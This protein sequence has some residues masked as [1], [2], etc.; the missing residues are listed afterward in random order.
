MNALFWLALAFVFILFDVWLFFEWF[1]TA[2]NL[3]GLVALASV[4]TIAIIGAA[5]CL[6]RHYLCRTAL[7]NP[8]LYLA[9]MQW[10]FSR[11]LTDAERAQQAEDKERHEQALVKHLDRVAGDASALLT[12]A[13]QH[14]IK[15]F[16]KDMW[17]SYEMSQYDDFT[18]GDGWY[19]W[20]ETGAHVYGPYSTVQTAITQRNEY[21]DSL[22][23]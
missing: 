1:W 17:D 22:E 4:G 19:W 7:R 20:D 15:Y 8:M 2:P 14:G 9:E 3:P 12:L 13:D 11:P 6:H 18:R 10:H 16:T 21:A 5:M 23:A